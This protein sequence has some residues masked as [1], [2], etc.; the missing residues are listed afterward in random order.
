LSKA[1]RGSLPGGGVGVRELA[2]TSRMKAA[3]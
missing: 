3:N 2:M 1:V